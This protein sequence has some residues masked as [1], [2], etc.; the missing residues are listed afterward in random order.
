MTVGFVEYRL[1]C[2][3]AESL[4]DKRHFVKGLI[5][6]CRNAG[7]SASETDDHDLLRSVVVGVAIVESSE[8]RAAHWFDQIESWIESQTEL[9]IESAARQFTS[10]EAEAA[11]G[12]LSE[13]FHVMRGDID[14][15]SPERLLTGISAARAAERLPNAP[16][17]L[18]TNLAH[19]IFWQEHWLRKSRRDAKSTVDWRADWRVPEPNEFGVLRTRLIEGVAAAEELSNDPHAD[20]EPLAAILVHTSYHM[21]QLNLLKR[22]SRPAK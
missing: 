7:G 1:R 13:A 18:L 15:P 10:P 9:E 16:Y 3:Y 11:G 12:G 14:I 21:G 8:A 22:M 20:Q 6:R 4:K 17:S 2:P 19:T 5:D